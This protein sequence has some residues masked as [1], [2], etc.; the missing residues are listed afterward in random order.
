M[1][2]DLGGTYMIS[3]MP[4]LLSFD[5]GEAQTATKVVD[6]KQMGSKEFLE[7]WIRKEAARQV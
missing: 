5:R 6:V 2:S 7:G 3:S 1:R 4:T